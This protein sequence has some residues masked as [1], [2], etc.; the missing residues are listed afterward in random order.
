M[1]ISVIFLLYLWLY[2]V[3]FLAAHKALQI[4]VDDQLLY[5][6]LYF[7]RCVYTSFTVICSEKSTP[8]VFY[9]RIQVLC[10]VCTYSPI[11]HTKKLYSVCD[12]L[13]WIQHSIVVSLH[14]IDVEA[15]LYVVYLFPFRLGFIFGKSLVAILYCL[16]S[17]YCSITVP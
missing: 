6:N 16:W 2:K 4:C 17:I 14:A 13:Q 3:Y 11:Q 1:F 8:S 10:V 15:S 5:I 12:E 9:V 7:A